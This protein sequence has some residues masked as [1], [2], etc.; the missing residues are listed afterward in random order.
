MDSSSDWTISD[1]SSDDEYLDIDGPCPCGDGSDA[2]K[3]RTMAWHHALWEEVNSVKVATSS[4]IFGIYLFEQQE[5]GLSEVPW[6]HSIDVSG[7]TTL[8][9]IVHWLAYIHCVKVCQ[10]NLLRLDTGPFK[11]VTRLPLNYTLDTCDLEICEGDTVVYELDEK[12][13]HVPSS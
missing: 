3:K 4:T 13:K 10:V 2:H 6:G 5:G 11:E 12:L 8:K 1:V 7:T 9:D